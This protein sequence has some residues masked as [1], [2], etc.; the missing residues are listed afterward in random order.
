MGKY[1]GQRLVAQPEL[2]YQ[3]KRYCPVLVALEGSALWGNTLTTALLH[4]LNRTIPF[5]LIELF[6]KG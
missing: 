2:T 6:G 3:S 5:G 1:I 4:Y